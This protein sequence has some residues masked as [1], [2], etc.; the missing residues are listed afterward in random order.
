MPALSRKLLLVLCVI[1]FATVVVGSTADARTSKKQ[2][3]AQKLKHKK[4]KKKTKKK[5]KTKAKK[6]RAAKPRP[7]TGSTS[8]STSTSTSTGSTAQ[9]AV[10]SDCGNVSQIPSATNATGTQTTVL[11]L[12]NN[13]RARAGLLALSLNS[14]L[15]SA[16]TSHSQDM[17]SNQFFAH[18][19]PS[20]STPVSRMTA[21]GYIVSGRSWQVGENIA[22]GTGSYGT[23]GSIMVA[24]MNSPPHRENILNPSF[25]D[26]GVGI[27]AGNPSGVQQPGATY[28]TDFGVRG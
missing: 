24:W 19:S 21:I 11:C 7:P 28:T 14:P 22:W 17:V 23:P 27:V 26:V 4:K 18:N 8:G 6:R 2:R 1:L 5:A 16:A 9:Q 20:G 25:R 3:T 12:L 10:V 15:N 13:E